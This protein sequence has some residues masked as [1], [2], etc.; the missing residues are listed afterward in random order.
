LS[1]RV[2]A[3]GAVFVVCSSAACG[4][5]DNPTTAP[6]KAIALA[7][8]DGNDQSGPAG[9]L[10]AQPLRVTATDGKQVAV[11]GAI[12]RFRV[13]RGAE[14]GTALTDTVAVA[15]FDGTA[16]VGLRLGTALDSSIEEAFL[17]DQPTVIARFRA[18]ATPPPR[19]TAV[20]PASFAAGDT[21]RLRGQFFNVAVAGNT[22][23]FGSARGRI[24]R[25][26][27]D[28]SLTVVVPPCVSSGAVAARVV[29]GSTATNTV[30]ATFVASSG[31]LALQPLEGTTVTG[32][33]LGACI[34][35]RGGGASY[36]IVPQSATSAA[37][38]RQVDFALSASVPTL[39][40]DAPASQPAPIAVIPPALTPRDRF[41]LALRQREALLVEDAR[42]A[43]VLRPSPDVLS[44]QAFVAPPAVGSQRSFQVLSK[45]DGSAFKR[46]TARVRYVGD[47]II[48]YVDVDQ[49]P[50][51]LSDAEL[52]TFGEL[53]DRT[54]YDLDARAFGRESDIDANGRVIFLLTPVVN[55]LTSASECSTS[56]FITGFHFG[57]DLLPNQVNSNRGEIFYALV[58]DVGG[59]RSCEHTKAD[60]ERVVPAT[61]VHEFQH[62]ISFGQHVL[63]RGGASEALWLN[64]GLSHIAEEL[65]GKTYEAKF[66]PPLGRTDPNQLFPDSAQGYLTPNMRNAQSFLQ[67]PGTS[68]ITAL[69]GGGTLA[70]RGG[71]WLFLRWLGDQKGESI[72]GRLVQTGRTG[73]A[74]IEDKA[75]ESFAGLFGDFATAIYTDSLPGISRAQIPSRLRFTTR[76]FRVVFKR[77]ADLDQSGR[78]PA[79]PFTP[80]GLAAGESASGTVA[81]GSMVYYQLTTRPNESTVGL[82]F[83]RGDLSSFLADDQVQIG[84]F[85][86]P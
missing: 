54:L 70:E 79:F 41:D 20:V 42:A 4:K 21:V 26:D 43:G 74:N 67:R 52:R 82:R 40:T 16:S 13:A 46:I 63:A 69:T 65:A 84:I 7:I 37:G 30:A 76:N 14:T 24:V 11:P 77:F 2:L 29:V 71:S 73:V 50:G 55:A 35:L 64:E 51:T 81:Q 28:T 66:P 68:S 3:S 49:P 15:T 17:P 72:Y 47:H 8:K 75:N 32:T 56:G 48:L 53:F 6:P 34:Q 31:L 44:R 83:S 39:G 36:L 9:G 1:N 61:F 25:G 57:L 19:L 86:L 45:F 10:L 38:N 59:T 85:R 58:P 5:N 23:F 33:E 18:T 62:M 80:V 22:A 27:A 12:V 78:T 60:V